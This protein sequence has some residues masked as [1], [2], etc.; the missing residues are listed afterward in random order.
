MIDVNKISQ[1]APFTSF[2]GFE[3]HSLTGSPT[4]I[5]QP[6]FSFTASS[7]QQPITNLCVIPVLA[8]ILTKA[9]VTIFKYCFESAP[10]GF[11]VM[12]GLHQKL[13][14]FFNPI[15]GCMSFIIRDV[16]FRRCPFL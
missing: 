8:N 2:P 4:L 5:L 15:M 3:K 11:L 7:W 12:E 6:G 14:D 10:I 9:Q 1:R 16:A 13:V